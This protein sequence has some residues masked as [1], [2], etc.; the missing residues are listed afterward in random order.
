MASNGSH[1]DLPNNIW[2]MI[3]S[4]SKEPGEQMLLQAI[5]ASGGNGSDTYQVEYQGNEEDTAPFSHAHAWRYTLVEYSSILSG[6]WGMH[7]EG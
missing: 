1:I 5:M 6:H 7:R 2:A 3:S 4:S